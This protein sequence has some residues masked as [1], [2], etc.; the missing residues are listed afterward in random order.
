MTQFIPTTYLDSGYDWDKDGVVDIW[1]NYL[2][3]FASIANY[4]TT[5]DKNPWNKNV[6]W[7]REVKP[8]DNIHDIFNL[9]KQ[10]DPKGCGAVK[11]RSV[12]KKLIE[13]HNLGFKNIDGS[14][15]PFETN[16][17]PNHRATESEVEF[18]F[19]SN[20]LSFERTFDGNQIL[21]LFS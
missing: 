13:W 2:D 9:L 8:P 4:L 7:G 1:N 20:D 15:I 18:Q 11:S 19:F 16:L 21:I 6:T 3:A 5:I 12:P 14:N 10:K 17:L